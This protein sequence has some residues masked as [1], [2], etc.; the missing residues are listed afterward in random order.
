MKHTKQRNKQNRKQIFYSSS[1]E[2]KRSNGTLNLFNVGMAVNRNEFILTLKSHQ[3]I[4]DN[5]VFFFFNVYML[6][7]TYYLSM[8]ILRNLIECSFNSLPAL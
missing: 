1:E 6:L 4:D 7:L 8:F 2:R 3:V 5:C